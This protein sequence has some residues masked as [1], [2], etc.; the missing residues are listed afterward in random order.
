MSTHAVLNLPG[1]AGDIKPVYQLSRVSAADSHLLSDS[2][3]KYHTKGGEQKDNR[4]LEVEWV[5]DGDLR[6]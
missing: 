4:Y 2:L 6:M 1:L 5:S 3:Y